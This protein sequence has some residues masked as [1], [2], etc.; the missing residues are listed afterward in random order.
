M[1]D[2][3]RWSSVVVTALANGAEWIE[4]FASPDAAT[5]RATQLGRD[6]TILG[7]ERG[8]IALPG[9]DLGNSPLE[10]T[11]ARVH[12]R[13]V[14]TTTTNGTQAIAAASEA[15]EVL[16]GAFLNLDAVVRRL[17]GRSGPITLICAGQAG[18]EA[19]EDSACAG[20]IAE[21]LGDAG[22]DP[23]TEHALRTWEAAGRDAARALALAPHGMAL[24]AAG[25][26][27]DLAF[28][29]S[30]ARFDLVPARESVGGEPF[31]RVDARFPNAARIVSDMHPRPPETDA[32]E[33]APGRP[34][35]P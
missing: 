5:A 23:A 33:A 31:P 6:R 2:V 12:G 18:V 32:A 25:F 35:P 20:A 26:G 1:I 17:R 24:A 7:G 8:N 4:A 22:G 11:T 27:A 15:A 29:A 13:A 28:A 14:I 3:L 10:Y 19:S 9:F 34:A 30:L 16:V 21:A